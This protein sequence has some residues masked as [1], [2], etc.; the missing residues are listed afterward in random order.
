[1]QHPKHPIGPGKLRRYTTIL[2]RAAVLLVLVG[3]V[4]SAI[5]ATGLDLL[6]IHP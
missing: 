2:V 1:M 5:I 4:T 3:A 6:P